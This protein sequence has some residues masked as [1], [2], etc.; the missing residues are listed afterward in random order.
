MM[1]IADFLVQSIM[2]FE[3]NCGRVIDPVSS[4]YLL[5]RFAVNSQFKYVPTLSPII[6]QPTSA[7]PVK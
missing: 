7:R 6:V 5:K 4:V 2:V 3:K 1:S